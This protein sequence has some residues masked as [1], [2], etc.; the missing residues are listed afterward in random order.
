MN[1]AHFE[2][3]LLAQSRAGIPI[4]LGGQVI[5]FLVGL[6]EAAVKR[7]V[8]V[9]LYCI[10]EAVTGV[11]DD[12]LQ[13]LRARGLRLFACAY[14]ARRRGC[15]VSDQALFV[16]LGTLGDLIAGTDRFLSFN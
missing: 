13:A 16:G 14:A 9:Y 6:A 12:R 3:F 4:A 1:L 7:G 8:E 2:D 15:A 10:D 11:G 5:A